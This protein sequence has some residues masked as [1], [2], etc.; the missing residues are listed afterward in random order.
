MGKLKKSLI[1]QGFFGHGSSSASVI[2]TGFYPHKPFNGPITVQFFPEVYG[3]FQQFTEKEP[4]RPGRLG[5]FSLTASVISTGHKAK[6]GSAPDLP[7][8]SIDGDRACQFFIRT[9]TDAV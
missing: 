9:V 3:N 1:D 5:L 8:T 6:V 2:S 4:H 7:H